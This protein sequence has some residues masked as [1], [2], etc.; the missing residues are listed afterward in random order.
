ML[1]FVPLLAKSGF[2]RGAQG[3]VSGCL[4]VVAAVLGV[5][6]CAVEM[7]EAAQAA[8]PPGVVAQGWEG[9]YEGLVL[10][11]AEG[12]D[13]ALG[14]GMVNLKVTRAGRFS[15]LVRV[16]GK[17]FSVLG[18][19]GS[20]GQGFFGKSESAQIVL[21]RSN[22]PGLIFACEM[23]PAGAG[24]IRGTLI[25]EG[26]GVQ[27]RIGTVVMERV[28]FDGKTTERTLP[29][30]RFTVAVP[31]VAQS[32]GL[33]R[34]EFPRGS[35]VGTLAFTARTGMGALAMTL[36]DGT[37]LALRCRFNERKEA[38]FYT[39]L[40]QGGGSFQAA[41]FGMKPVQIRILRMPR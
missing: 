20:D 7:A 30:A 11:T 5:W 23:D 41:W 38:V 29:D 37:S 39:A 1:C 35:G 21:R 24:C 6:G 26:S 13:S 25:E 8:E 18:G 16:A 28:F 34:S 32:F 31:S 15:G 14:H 3:R 33:K 22:K 9:D 4:R 27:E 40:Y 2:G 17:M 36:A 12:S 19:F 10:P